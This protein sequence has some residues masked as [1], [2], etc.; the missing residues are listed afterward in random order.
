[1][2]FSLFFFNVY[3]IFQI[4]LRCFYNVVL[5]LPY[6]NTHPPWVYTCSPSLINL[7]GCCGLFSCSM[8][9]LVPWP[10]I[11]PGPPELGTQCLS[12][13]TTREV[14]GG[15]FKMIFSVPWIFHLYYPW[16]GF[17]FLCSSHSLLTK[18]AWN[19]DLRLLC[20][21]INT[22]FFDRFFF[23]LL[24]RNLTA[25]VLNLG[26]T[27]PRILNLEWAG[28]ELSV[29]LWFPLFRADFMDV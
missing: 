7:I 10:G 1:M 23:P 19:A 11:K 16:I 27:L 2:L 6:I 18:N 15:F 13:W 20:Y 24:V 17:L 26:G 9:D 4:P 5:V 3:I 29:R 22:L 25:N 21:C 14:P 12:H 28:I 8:R